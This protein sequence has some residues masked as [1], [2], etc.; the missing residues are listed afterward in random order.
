MKKTVLINLY[1]PANEE[2]ET[3]E[4]LLV[5]PSIFKDLTERVQ[6]SVGGRG[7]HFILLVGEHGIGKSHLLALLRDRLEKEQPK[8]LSIVSIDEEELSSQ[9]YLSFLL[10]VIGSLDCIKKEQREKLYS[11][12]EQQTT[13]AAQE[14]LASSIGGGTLLLLC[15]GLD[16]LL[17][18]LGEEG[19]KRWRAFIAERPFWAIIAT[20]TKLFPAIKLQTAPFYGF[21]TIRN[22]PRLDLNSAIEL[23]RKRVLLGSTNKKLLQLIE[24]PIGRSHLAAVHHL[25]GGLPRLLLMAAEYMEGELSEGLYALLVGVLDSV[26]PYYREQLTLL[27]PQQRAIFRFLC[28]QRHPETVKAI[29]GRCF[30]TSQTA[31]KQ[32]GVMAQLGFV[33]RIPMGRESFYEP[34]ETLLQ[35]CFEAKEGHV[36][37]LRALSLFLQ[38]WFTP[39]NKKKEKPRFLA[40]AKSSGLAL[41]LS[42]SPETLKQERG[43]LLLPLELRALLVST[44]LQNSNEQQYLKRAR[45][46]Q[47]KK[48]TTKTSRSSEEARTR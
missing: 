18:G 40:L 31:A 17:A 47:R 10:R 6:A 25:F 24:S 43:E 19:Q 23:V 15:D 13:V 27:S 41:V 4:S 39:Q 29:A 37:Y 8:N 48:A 21:F 26:L 5:Y 11:L 16:G 14:L 32:L 46:K 35:L 33:T 3:R 1:S 30:I 7:K 20:S 9:S 2:P 34:R 38:E 22:L 44:H 42:I 36:E 45:N 28:H 12:P